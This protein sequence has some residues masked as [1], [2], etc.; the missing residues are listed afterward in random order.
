MKGNEQ[1]RMPWVYLVVL[2]VTIPGLVCPGSFFD[3]YQVMCP[4]KTV[5]DDTARAWAYAQDIQQQYAQYAQLSADEYQMCI[6][7]LVGMITCLHAIVVR[8]PMQGMAGEDKAYYIRII[9]RFESDCYALKLTSC[10][11]A[12]IQ[13]LFGAVYAALSQANN[14]KFSARQYQSSYTYWQYPKKAIDRL[15]YRMC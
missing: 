14:A 8:M 7:T 3:T 9:Q 2:I 11:R 12:I 13:E 10:Q 6:Y 15:Q 1:G 4:F 5:L